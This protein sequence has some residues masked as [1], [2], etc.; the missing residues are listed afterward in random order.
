MTE[1][2]LVEKQQPAAGMIAVASS[3]EAQQVQ[4]AMVI[5]QKF[6]RDTTQAFNRIMQ[7]CKRKSLAEKAIYTYPRGGQMVSG[8]SIR[9]AEAMAQAWGNLDFGLIELDSKPSLGNVP[10]ESTM[11]AYCFDLETNTRSTKV[12]TVRHK[13]DTKKGSS[14][15]KDERD[16]YE[17][18]ANNGARRLRSCILNVIPA[19]II[20]AA[21]DQCEESMKG[22]DGPLID[23]V[24]AMTT[25]FSELGVSQEMLERRLMHKIDVTTE[26]ELVQLRKIFTSIKDGFADRS[27]YFEVDAPTSSAEGVDQSVDE[28]SQSQPQEIN[29][30]KKL[31]NYAP[32]TSEEAKN[33]QPKAAEQD[34]GKLE[35]KNASAPAEAPGL[36]REDLTKD[37]LAAAKILKLSP[38]GLTQKFMT[39]A[40][41]P[42]A[43]CSSAELESMLIVL[44]AEIENAK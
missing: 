1:T 38:E 44:K 28:Q 13:R 32:Q 18:T 20:E 14:L 26:A 40:N 23:R 17:I 22:G 21:V 37:I 11:M 29:S 9:L 36:N 10:G 5:A 19:D 15:L 2:A 34:S 27:A 31:K 24:R 41:K 3:R 42:P 4:A 39:L 8:P 12:F 16:I 30:V 35:S 33:W 43:Q 6:P 7:A 25:V